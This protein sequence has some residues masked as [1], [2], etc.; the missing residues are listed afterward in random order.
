MKKITLEKIK[1]DN[2]NMVGDDYIVHY[3]NE[4]RYL[5]QCYDKCIVII[6]TSEKFKKKLIE[7]NYILNNNKW[8]ME[9]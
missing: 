5:V 9:N 2:P 6:I 1:S 3:N 7:V 8:K 4:D